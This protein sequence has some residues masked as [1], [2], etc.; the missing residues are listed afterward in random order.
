MPCTVP[1][2]RLEQ[3]VSAMVE[4]ELLPLFWRPFKNIYT[5]KPFWSLDWNGFLAL[6]CRLY[7]ISYK[8]KY[9]TK[10]LQPT[11]YSQH[12]TMR[13]TILLISLICARTLHAQEMT[14]ESYSW[15]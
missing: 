7:A 9:S 13:Y 14:I 10:S 2:K 4:E 1:I 3:Q 6:S 12:P 5:K 11:A 15:R 8:L